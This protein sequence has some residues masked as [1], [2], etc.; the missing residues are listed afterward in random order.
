MGDREQARA[1]D[2]PNYQCPPFVRDIPE[3]AGS[4]GWVS[5]RYIAQDDEGYLWADGEQ[6]PLTSLTQNNGVRALLAWSEEGLAVWVDPNG[7]HALA[8]IKG[9]AAQDGW[10]P[11]SVAMKECPLYARE[12]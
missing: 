2:L 11:V 7:Y 10:I 1:M 3:H 6:A 12:D 8:R 4:W 5:S 9:D